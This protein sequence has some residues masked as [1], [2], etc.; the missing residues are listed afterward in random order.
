MEPCLTSNEETESVLKAMRVICISPQ[1]SWLLAS[2]FTGKA[3]HLAAVLSQACLST[4][5][6]DL[7]EE[8]EGHV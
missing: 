4:G 6:L 5:L 1:S 3:R 2:A 8:S 7:L